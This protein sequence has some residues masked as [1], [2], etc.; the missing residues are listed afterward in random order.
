MIRSN[1]A[2]RPFYN[3]RA[4]RLWLLVAGLVVAAATAF[5][6]TW[7]L[8]YSRSDTELARQAASDEARIVELRRDAATL[9]ASV[10]LKQI[11]VASVEARRAND[12]IDR[13]TFSWTELFNRFEQTLP[14]NV[15]I[16]AVRPR[17]DEARRIVLTI[18]VVARSV[19]DVDQ[20]MANLDDTGA[21]A[22]LR[23]SE[24]RRNEAGQ[25]ETSL[26]ALYVAAPPTGEPP[27]EPAA[28]R[29]P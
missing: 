20:F 6:V 1:L 21:F 12:L 8:R 27:P 10:D 7:M 13:R 14:P 16:T 5:N 4:V 19:A 9:R 15:R 2:T 22:E 17:L 3:E 11:Q 23:P 26:D 28:E 24:E 29:A 18:S 25:I